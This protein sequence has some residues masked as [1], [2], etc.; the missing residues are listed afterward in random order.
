MSN[1]SIINQRKLDHLKENGEFIF[2]NFENDYSVKIIPFYDKITNKQ[3]LIEHFNQLTNVNIRVEDLVGKLHLVI[4]KLLIDEDKSQNPRDI[5]INSIGLSLNSIQFLIDNLN[6]IKG[7]F[8]VRN[9]Y[10][11]ENKSNDEITFSYS[12]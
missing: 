6:I 11:L 3:K 1:L 8:K 9:I 12:K 2:I 4:L 10:I 7:S 5:I